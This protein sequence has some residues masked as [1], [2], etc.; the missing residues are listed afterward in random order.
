MNLRNRLYR[1]F[2]Q[3]NFQKFNDRHFKGLI[4]ILRR[5]RPNCSTATGFEILYDAYMFNLKKFVTA[6][7]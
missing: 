4:Y 6:E 1:K 5:P 2:H 3:F 7:N